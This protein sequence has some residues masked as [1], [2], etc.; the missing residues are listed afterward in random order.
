MQ[1]GLKGSGE[2]GEGAVN[3]NPR[4]RKVTQGANTERDEYYVGVKR[5][6]WR[7][8]ATVLIFIHRNLW[9]KIWTIGNRRG[10]KDG[11]ANLME[12]CETK[13]SIC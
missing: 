7:L 3:Y 13:D 8:L 2:N 10:Y 12:D 1:L 11:R 4:K 9:R 5:T 6:I